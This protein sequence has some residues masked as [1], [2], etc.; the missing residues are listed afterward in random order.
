[1]IRSMRA[2]GGR[3]AITLG[4]GHSLVTSTGDDT[5][6]ASAGHETIGAVG[7]TKDVIYG[8]VRTLFFVT[9]FIVTTDG[10]ATVFGGTGTDTFFG[11]KR[12]QRAPIFW[13]A[14]PER[15]CCSAA[16]VAM[17]CPPWAARGRCCMLVPGPR[18]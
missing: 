15:Q 1:M 17:S 13:W 3:N 9:T 6:F 4:D 2:S 12:R 11:G 14:G 8:N 10:A 5:V 16:A 7:L 18:R